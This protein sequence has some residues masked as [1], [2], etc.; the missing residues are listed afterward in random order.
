MNAQDFAVV[1]GIAHYPY[2]RSLQGPVVDA[3]RVCE[4][5]VGPAGVPE[6]TNL[7]L[8]VS[9]ESAA[10]RPILGEIDAAFDRIFERA[11]SGARRLYVYFA[12]HGCSKAIDHLALLMANANP[13]RLNRAMNATE[14]RQSLATLLFPEQVYFFDCCRNYDA[15][16]T[17]RGPEWTVNEGATPVPNLTQVVLYAAGFTQYANERHL[18]YSERRGLFTEALLEGLNGGAATFDQASDSWV[19]RSDRLISF[20]YDRLKELTSG[21]QVEQDLWTDP[22]GVPRHLVLSTGVK[23]PLLQVTV[24]APGVTVKT[25][26]GAS[27]IVVLDERLRPIESRPVLDSQDTITFELP[28]GQYV[29]KAEPDGPAEVINLLDRP[30]HVDLEEL[31]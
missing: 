10:E 8:V 17:G 9:K 19:V 23:P 25:P 11:A 2:L 7:E 31:I 26:A 3:E 24:K 29:I 18:L 16:I 13:Q 14:Y 20:V 21:E 1:I 5:L 12:G 4:W 22:R 28:P 27:R 6:D 15:R 30:L